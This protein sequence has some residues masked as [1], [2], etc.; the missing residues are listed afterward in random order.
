MDEVSRLLLLLSDMTLLMNEVSRLLLLLSDMTLLMNEVSRLL[1]LLS[2]MTL[3]MN[4][5]SRLLLL[6]FDMTINTPKQRDR[7]K[8]NGTRYMPWTLSFFPVRAVV[9]T[10]LVS[11]QPKE[12]SKPD[13]T[14][15]MK[16]ENI[17]K[18]GGNDKRKEREPE[19]DRERERQRE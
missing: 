11:S 14:R 4:K 1:L 10:Y 17:T 13:L 6:L 16:T 7:I 12:T 15:K 19:R 8:Q 2:D 18:G 9:R 5:V 3:L